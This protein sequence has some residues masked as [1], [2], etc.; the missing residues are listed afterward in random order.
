LGGQRIVVLRQRIFDAREF[1][2]RLLVLNIH[3]TG[4][5]CLRIL[6]NSRKLQLFVYAQSLFDRLAAVGNTGVIAIKEF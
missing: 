6:G 2:A 4:R 5:G 3:R 1:L